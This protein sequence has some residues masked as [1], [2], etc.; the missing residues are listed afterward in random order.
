MQDELKLYNE[1]G[2]ECSLSLSDCPNNE[3]CLDLISSGINSSSNY[4]SILGLL[5]SVCQQTKANDVLFCDM[6]HRIIGNSDENS[7][8]DRLVHFFPYTHP[9][10]R[11]HLFNIKHYTGVVTYAV[12]NDSIEM[13]GGWIESNMDA[14][15]FAL[16]NLMKTSDNFILK[17]Y[18][19]AVSYQNTSVVSNT[20][21]LSRQKLRLKSVST[22]FVNSIRDLLSA[23]K[24]SECSFIRCIK[25]NETMRPDLIDNSFMIKQIRSLALVQTSQVMQ[26]GFQ[27]SLEYDKISEFLYS[28]L[29]SDEASH[30]SILDSPFRIL[31]SSWLIA[32]GIEEDLFIL[33]KS[34]VFF[35]QNFE[36]NKSSSAY[37]LTKNQQAEMASAKLIS[38]I[39]SL[40][41]REEVIADLHK[42]AQARKNKEE[43]LAKFKS[44]IEHF[45]EK[46]DEVSKH[47]KS[48]QS[49]NVPSLLSFESLFKLISEA[50]AKVELAHV[51]MDN[52]LEA[53]RSVK[54]AIETSEAPV[55]EAELI[56]KRIKKRVEENKAAYCRITESL[57]TLLQFEEETRDVFLKLQESF[58][59]MVLDYWESV[60]VA[61]K[62]LSYAK[63]LLEKVDHDP[64]HQEKI[65]AS[66]ES[67]LSEVDNLL[68]SKL[69]NERSQCSE[70]YRGQFSSQDD[71]QDRMM[72]VAS[73]VISSC[74]VVFEDCSQ[75]CEM[76]KDAE[77]EVEESKVVRMQNALQ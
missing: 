43:S 59:N 41:P 47:L 67:N 46:V 44:R 52:T 22:L 62:L 58:N 74:E 9:K 16:E 33:G 71:A 11:A 6:I 76:C 27:C 68:A 30:A 14:I 29:L 66:I 4:P 56:E 77:V 19:N 34:K 72:G 10:D 42:L 39:N 45:G 70:D 15:P 18:V 69:P 32:S 60:A 35:R 2:I 50:N 8:Y 24:E 61:R 3:G 12:C 73:G 55:K 54:S 20:N 57:Q 5:D 26:M 25:P 75:I 31:V 37:R 7:E 23:L 28:K 36:I 51:K 21:N 64:T 17:N 40:R 63:S 38:Y 1:E 49:S 13:G 48:Y 53:V 65:A